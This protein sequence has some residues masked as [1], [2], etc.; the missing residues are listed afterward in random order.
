MQGDQSRLRPDHNILTSYIELVDTVAW[1]SHLELVVFAA[2]LK[3]FFIEGG[4]QFIVGAQTA[5]TI[6]LKPTE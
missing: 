1:D 4:E 5:K 2:S 6:G 3:F